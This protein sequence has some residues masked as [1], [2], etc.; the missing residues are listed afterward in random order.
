[1]RFFKFACL[2]AILLFAVQG[3]P[4]IADDRI[5]T[6]PVQLT[7][8]DGVKLDGVLRRPLSTR[9]KVGFVMVHGYSGNF[10]SGV[11]SFLPAELSNLGFATLAVNMRDHDRTPK[12]NLFEKNRDDIAAAVDEMTR[13]G[14]SPLFLYGHSMGTNRVLYY[15]AAT[16]DPRI[17]GALLTG[18]PGNLFQWNV[19]IF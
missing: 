15:L 11:M 18:P 10:Y 7:A 12:N 4:L 1:M 5:V 6:E 8:V 14:Y 17:A 9:K 13:R 16:Q 2:G 3:R 19:S